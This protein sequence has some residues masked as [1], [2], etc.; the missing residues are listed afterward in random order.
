MAPWVQGNA[1]EAPPGDRIRGL[2]AE[3]LVAQAVAVLEVHHPQVTLDLRDRPQISSI[4]LR[5]PGQATIETI[6]FVPEAEAAPPIG[7]L[8]GKDGIPDLADAGSP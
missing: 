7:G 5:L 8:V 4:D 2:L 3:R 6:S 1:A